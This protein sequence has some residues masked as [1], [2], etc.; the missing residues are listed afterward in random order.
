MCNFYWN[1]IHCKYPVLDAVSDFTLKMNA[2]IAFASL[3]TFTSKTYIPL[4][5]CSEAVV[6][7]KQRESDVQEF[8]MVFGFSTVQFIWCALNVDDF[9]IADSQKGCVLD[10]V[11]GKKQWKCIRYSGSIQYVCQKYVFVIFEYDGFNEYILF[12][13]FPIIGFWEL[14]WSD[15][16]FVK[17]EYRVPCPETLELL[18]WR[19]KRW[20]CI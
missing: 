19:L 4:R 13:W 10:Y 15:V 16:E 14:R 2:S 17:K 6:A 9:V 3:Q 1:V 7:R 8:L 20:L 18:I 12:C 11:I 5:K